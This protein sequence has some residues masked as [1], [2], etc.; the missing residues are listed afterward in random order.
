M[1]N[2]SN[3][4]TMKKAEDYISMEVERYI[5]FEL[6][7]PAIVRIMNLL[8]E[9]KEIARKYDSLNE[10]QQEACKELIERLNKEICQHL[11]IPV[12]KNK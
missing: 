1:N 9:R 2:E 12:F 11:S 5:G 3:P 6:S 10:G 8:N 4:E 7:V